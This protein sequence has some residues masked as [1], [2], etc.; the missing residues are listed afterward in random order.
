[1]HTI[2]TPTNPN[3]F[4]YRVVETPTVTHY[5]LQ[6]GH[7]L[8]GL[9]SRRPDTPGWWV[10]LNDHGCIRRDGEVIYFP[11]AEAALIHVATN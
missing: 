5:D 9:I 2:E 3:L 11:T 7:S 10:W 1:M 8:I 4:A 6:D